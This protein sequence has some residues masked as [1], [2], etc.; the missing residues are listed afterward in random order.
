MKATKQRITIDW[1]KC[2]KGFIFYIESILS[3]VNGHMVKEL[4]R[5]YKCI[6]IAMSENFSKLT[7]KVFPLR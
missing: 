4:I 2:A 1:N 7:R 3:T 5:K 6:K